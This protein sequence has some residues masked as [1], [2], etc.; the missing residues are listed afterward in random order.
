MPLF[1]PHSGEDESGASLQAAPLISASAP[2]PSALGLSSA[3]ICTPQERVDLTFA[4]GGEFLRMSEP[5]GRRPGRRGGGGKRGTIEGFSYASRRRMMDALAAVDRAQVKCVFFGT[6]TAPHLTWES[7]EAVRRRWVG[8]LERR[9][10]GHRWS[11][12]WRK[13][14][15]ASGRPHL[16]W[17]LIWL[18]DAPHLVNS[19]RPW[20]DRAWAES[21]GRP[22]IAGTCCR[23]E[24]IRRWSG[25]SSYCSK[26]CAKIVEGGE[27]RQWG[28]SRREFWPIT[29]KAESVPRPVWVLAVRVLRRVA[30]GR[31]G[32]YLIRQGKGHPWIEAGRRWSE[33]RYDADGN[34]ISGDT[35]RSWGIQVRRVTPRFTRRLREQS[36]IEVDRD[37]RHD[38]FGAMAHAFNVKGCEELQSVVNVNPRRWFVDVPTLQRV[39]RWAS[40]EWLRRLEVD[41]LLPF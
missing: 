5:Y 18:D 7:I 29:L 15:H 10:A 35:L 17:L 14:P 4:Q 40:A 36:R 24:M 30:Q 1:G 39:I 9:W 6:C 28:I 20:N 22:D 41:Q 13:E 31:S 33:L 21:T 34:P 8:R 37:L 38:S 27:G 16:H 25:A 3:H 26:Y 2:L 11:L 23:V 12:M 32:R 19:F